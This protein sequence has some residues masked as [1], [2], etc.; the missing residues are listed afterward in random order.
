MNL[1][2]YGFGIYTVLFE[3]VCHKWWISSRKK[4]DEKS[5]KPSNK[6]NEKWFI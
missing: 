5:L 6:L 4:Y 2:E 1:T 3:N